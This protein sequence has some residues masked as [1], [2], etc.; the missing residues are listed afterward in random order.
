MSE[1]QPCPLCGSE[2]DARYTS[3]PDAPASIPG[4]KV[5]CCKSECRCELVVSHPQ[6]YPRREDEMEGIALERWNRRCA[7]EGWQLVPVIPTEEM[8]GP[9]RWARHLVYRQMLDAA[10]KPGGE[11]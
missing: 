9:S 7:P 10:P 2:V 6:V 4:F 8:L 5:T 1:F 11:R 3:I